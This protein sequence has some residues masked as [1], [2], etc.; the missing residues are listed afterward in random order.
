MAVQKSANTETTLT[1]L[2]KYLVSGHLDTF[3]GY[4]HAWCWIG[5][6]FVV[7]DLDDAKERHRTELTVFTRK[8]LD[9]WVDLANE[10]I[11]DSDCDEE[12]E[13]I[14]ETYPEKCDAPCTYD[15][16]PWDSPKWTN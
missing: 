5:D 14:M 2:M 13:A 12:V 10:H 9:E 1:S 11:T 4:E 6:A 15:P 7:A 16:S 3:G 8:E